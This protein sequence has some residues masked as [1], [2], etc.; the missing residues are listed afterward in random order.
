MK[1]PVIFI[2]INIA[3]IV[4]LSIVQVVVANGISTSGIELS[5]VQQQIGELKRSNAMLHEQ[6]LTASSLTS[7]AS[8]ASSMGFEEEKS[9]LVISSPLPLARR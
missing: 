4:G 7:I 9:P 6:I 1:K 3:I 2:V 5:K 8:I